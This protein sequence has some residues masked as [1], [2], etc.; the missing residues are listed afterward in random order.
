[1]GIHVNARRLRALGA[2]SV[3]ALPLMFV[4]AAIAITAALPAAASTR[5]PRAM[6]MQVIKPSRYGISQ[7]L[8]G[9]Q[10]QL[11]ADVQRIIGAQ[12]LSEEQL[13][14]LAAK[15]AAAGFF[16]PPSPHE[17]SPVGRR[18]LARA[19]PLI[20]KDS[21]LQRGIPARSTAPTVT[22]AANFAG[23]TNQWGVYPPDNDIAVGESRIIEMVNNGFAVFDKQG[24][25]L[26]GPTDTNTLWTGFGGKCETRNDG[27]PV[28][29]YDRTAHRWLLSQFTTGNAPYFECIAVSV[30]NDPTGRYYLYAFKMS[31]AVFPDYPKLAVWPDGYYATFNDFDG[32]N[33]AGITVAAYERS[34]MLDGNPD[35][36]MVLFSEPYSQRGAWSLLPAEFDG[37]NPPP[38]GQPELFVS[39]VS[40]NSGKEPPVDGAS[41]PPDYALEL[42]HMHVDWSNPANSTFSGPTDVAVPAFNDYVCGPNRNCIPQPNGAPGLD[43]LSD[44]LMFRLAYRNFGDH[45]AVVVN[46]TVSVGTNDDPPTGVR[47][48]QLS[49][50]A[51][52]ADDWSLAQAGTWAPSDGNSRWMGSIAMDEEGDLLLGYSVSGPNLDPSI[53]FTGRLAGDPSEQM[54]LPEHTVIAGAGQ[55]TGYQN[56]WGDYSS[57]VGDPTDD[58]TFWY[59]NEYYPQTSQADWHTRI[60]A[61]RF[62]ACGGTDT[63]TLQGTV[64]DARDD[65]PVADAIITI[66]PGDIQTQ[67]DAD[68]HYGILLDA[69]TYT[70]TPRHYPFSTNSGEQADVTA[71]Q[72]TMINIALPLAPAVTLS[73]KVSDGGITAGMHGWGL[74]AHLALQVSQFGELS[75]AGDAYTTPET[76]TYSMQLRKGYNYVL[77]M[78]P[79]L[80]GYHDGY[81]PAVV[82]LPATDA[83]IVHDF[84]VGV[85]PECTAPGYSYPSHFAEDFDGPYFPPFLWSVTNDIQGSPVKWDTDRAFGKYSANWTGGADNAATVDANYACFEQGYCGPSD[86]SLVTPPIPVTDLG[87]ATELTY[88]A[89]FQSF[90]ATSTLDLDISTDGGTTWTTVV[91]WGE[92]HGGL[93]KLPGE[94]VRVDLAPY[95][96]ASGSLRLRW[97]YQ[98]QSF[99]GLYAQIDD[100]AIGNCSI[101]PGGLAI[102]E[103]T[104]ANTGGGLAGVQVADDLGNSAVT[105]LTPDDPLL[106]DLYVLATQAG[107]RTLTAFAAT[108]GAAA[109]TQVQIANDQAARAGAMVLGNADIA[110]SGVQGGT[111][112]AGSS[113]KAATVTVA[114][115][116]PDSA[117]D[118]TLHLKAGAGLKLLGAEAT[119]GEC[120]A[121]SAGIVC[122]LGTVA[123]GANA[124]VN[125][126]AFGISA[127][128]TTVTAT[129]TQSDTDLDPS[130]NSGSAQVD[131][132]APPSP[133]GGGGSGGGGFGWPMLVALLACAGL[134]TGLRR[135]RG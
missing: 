51:P 108:H 67:T 127:G 29:L 27:D 78:T 13:A 124:S 30:T 118:V 99:L 130:N 93:R 70:V 3:F 109:T 49:D 56:R 129:V 59:V 84:A 122:S 17:A 92:G 8:R 6:R 33:P 123:P 21:L 60:A 115:A 105:F 14:Q 71:G 45:E 61:A 57:M 88:R 23:I 116:G 55:Q 69:G 15:L 7:P 53:A 76:G 98:A 4:F 28:V 80:Q 107:K 35:A 64:T 133:G 38:A 85:K 48:Y 79:S 89:N 117:A 65:S 42:W 20:V 110:I 102:G 40:P 132:V 111:L 34:A 113:G 121:G 25:T 43:T 97:H 83:N 32:S 54:T 87:G 50:S 19:H 103:V 119:Q 128:A 36:R 12:K 68:G 112:P 10:W 72:T 1:M 96:P 74:Y 75:A 22:T 91:H 44:R 86:T 26:L 104:D 31:D 5:A 94:N 125:L 101:Q 73:G 82:N 66:E 18:P 114:N 46:Q 106:A 126:N 2:R 131:V 77:T 9:M 16:A 100:V 135:Q 120:T 62:D 24:N 63:G 47:W 95:L 90:D 37:Q 58:C 81:D 11:P 39:Y 52:G 134:L 41:T